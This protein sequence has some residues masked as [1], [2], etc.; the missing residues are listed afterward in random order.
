[1][2]WTRA[3]GL[4]ACLA[5]SQAQA[6][7]FYE[8]KTLAHPL[9][10]GLAESSATLAFIKTPAG[11]RGYY[12]VDEAQSQAQLLDDF[13]KAS[14]E[15][16][17][18]IALDNQHLTR[19]VLFKLQGNYHL[20]AYRYD[21]NDHLYSRLGNL[22]KALDR[23]TQGQRKLDAR[24][25]NQALSQLT[26]L[27]YR[28]SYEDS[29]I[30]EFDQLDHSAGTLVGYF[31]QDGQPL[32]NTSPGAEAYSYK[33]TFGEKQGRYLSVTYQRDQSPALV[34]G[35]RQLYNYQASRVTWD[36][37]PARL[38][39]S[40]DG[41]SVAY[42]EDGAIA[43][44]G[45]YTHGQ[46][47]GEW[48]FAG[49]SNSWSHGPYVDG[50]RQGQWS[51]SNESEGY[52]MTG[53]YRDDLREGRWD[54]KLS[55]S[56]ALEDGGFVTY[57][58]DLRNGPSESREG[59]AVLERGDYRDDLRQGP[60]LTTAGSGSYDRGLKSGPW[61]LKAADGHTHSVSFVA[62][63]MQGELRDTDAQGVLRVIE[64]YRDGLLWGTQEGYNDSGQLMYSYAYEN[65]QRE[66]RSLIYSADGKVLLSD[67]SYKNG[68]KQGPYLT[69]LADGSPA[70]VGRVE[71]SEF[72]GLM[73]QLDEHGQI[74][75]A[76]TRCRFQSYQSTV[77]LCGM[78]REFRQGRVTSERD[79]LYGELQEYREYNAQTGLKTRERVIGEGDQVSE[80]TYYDNGQVECRVNKVGFEWMT[81]NQQKLKNYNQAVLSGEQLCYY[82]NGVIKS[83][84]FF[85]KGPTGCKTLYDETGKQTFPGPSGCRR[86][87]SAEAVH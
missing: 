40:E 8:G 26:P 49:P 74:F 77:G 18:N 61:Q 45:P 66:G 87:T 2:Q 20:R 28:V 70:T 25:V 72:I 17:F 65:G 1:M 55:D 29:G 7:P 42:S 9:I 47:N 75:S 62:D 59:G 58:H 31:G 81:I 60:W 3:L 73:T 13:G 44:R 71:G 78:S 64:H 43:S 48:G 22:Q 46:R 33:K 84:D 85:D 27:N 86:P 30:A 16:V 23:I 76:A 19:L 56:E 52:G 10:T 57:L 67:M 5:L 37:E 15:S 6:A 32:G 79:Y 24:T 34:D 38:T 63:K 69:F 80:I 39:G 50:K 14:I 21:D 51:L 11:V 53:L 82:P 83:R 4:I 36:T 68:N 54:I 35:P 41:P 12:A